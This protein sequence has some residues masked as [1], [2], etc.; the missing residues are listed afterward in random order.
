MAGE[1]LRLFERL[2]VDI[3]GAVLNGIE[4]SDGYGYYGYVPGYEAV[5]EPESTDIVTTR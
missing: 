5:E 2:P 4:F 3:V 1:K